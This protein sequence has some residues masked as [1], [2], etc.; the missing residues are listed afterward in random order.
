MTP[1]DNIVTAEDG[2]PLHLYR[3]FFMGKQM[4]LR[5]PTLY[6]AQKKAA[7]LYGAGRKTWM[8]STVLIQKADGTDHPLDPASL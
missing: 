8:V 1:K 4:D 3:C 2:T 5:A 7:L 6:D